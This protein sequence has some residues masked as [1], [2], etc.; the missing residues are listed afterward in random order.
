M[1]HTLPISTNKHHRKTNKE[2]QYEKRYN[3]I[4]V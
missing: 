1:K 4:G 3:I 2:V